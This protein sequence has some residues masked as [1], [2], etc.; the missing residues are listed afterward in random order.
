MSYRNI[1]SS[2]DKKYT[3]NLSKNKRKIK[4]GQTKPEIIIAY[5]NE[6]QK[7]LYTKKKKKE[8]KMHTKIIAY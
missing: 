5:R 7:N 6:Y 4:G 3:C 1:Y 8:R 2:K